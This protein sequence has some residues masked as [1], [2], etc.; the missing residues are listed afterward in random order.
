[1]LYSRP[2]DAPR[3]A[4]SMSSAL[5][6]RAALTRG[7]VITLANWPVVLVG[8]V[9]ETAYTVALGVPILGGALMV[10]LLLRVD[11]RS[12]VG[13][14]LLSAAYLILIRL[15]TAPA[16]LAAFLAALAIVGVGGAV[17][18]FVVKAGALALLVK[19]EGTAPELHRRPG[20]VGVMRDASVYSLGALWDAIRHFERRAAVLAFWLGV[21]YVLIGCGYLLTVGWAA[22]LLLESAW[23][24][25]WP[26]L[27]L[28]ATSAA[29]VGIIAANLLF[30]LTR[31]VVVTDDCGVRVALERVRAF[32]LEDSRQVLGIF[33]AMGTILLLATAG[34]LTAT[35]GLA[36]VAWVPLAGLLFVPLQVAFWI[37]RGLLFEY[38]GLVTLSA[39]QTQYRRFGAPQ[40]AQLRVPDAE[41]PN[42]SVH[43]V[44]VHDVRVQD[45]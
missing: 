7:A 29:A 6:I 3:L 8:S 43:D 12:L 28:V 34:S 5:T 13:E 17:V 30:D 2:T 35:A 14:E 23:S 21:V 11:V 36:L 32:L 40:A 15:W 33:G 41:V 39:Y 20:G 19:G 9:V 25:A 26:L 44:S 18:M 4:S 24:A 27:V 38:M 10:S 45:R 22:R 16:A 42:V 1:M 31:V 37:L